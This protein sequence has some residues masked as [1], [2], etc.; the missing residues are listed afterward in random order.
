MR[1]EKAGLVLKAERLRAFAESRAAN[2][3]LVG[4][5]YPDLESDQRSILTVQ[6][7]AHIERRAVL[8]A[9]LPPAGAGDMGLVAVLEEDVVGVDGHVEGPFRT[10]LDSV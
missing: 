1:A 7:Q 5:G 9:L 8:D 3:A 4:T 6:Q 10:E 2:F